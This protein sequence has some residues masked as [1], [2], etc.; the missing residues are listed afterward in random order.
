MA[1]S[2]IGLTEAQLIKKTNA[3]LNSDIPGLKYLFLF[4]CNS[5]TVF[6]AV[7]CTN[8]QQRSIKKPKISI[9]AKKAKVQKIIQRIIFPYGQ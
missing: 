8:P 9:F 2:S 3:K 1:E 6:P 4:I 5:F 7:L